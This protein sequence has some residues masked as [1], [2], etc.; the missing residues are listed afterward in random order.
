MNDRYYIVLH[1]TFC[2]SNLSS[3]LEDEVDDIIWDEDD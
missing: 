2:G 1:C 3:E